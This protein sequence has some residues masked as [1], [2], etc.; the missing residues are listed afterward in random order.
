METGPVA[1]LGNAY[2]LR[3]QL[4]ETETELACGEPQ[5]TLNVRSVHDRVSRERLRKASAQRR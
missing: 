2:C 1:G 4:D 3:A 5:K